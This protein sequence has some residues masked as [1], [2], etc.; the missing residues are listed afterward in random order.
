MQSFPTIHRSGTDFSIRPST[1]CRNSEGGFVIPSRIG[2][3]RAGGVGL[4]LHHTDE[5][6]PQTYGKQAR[7]DLN[8]LCGEGEWG[9]S[10]DP[11]LHGI[12]SDIQSN[13]LDDATKK[14]SKYKGELHPSIHSCLVRLLKC[15]RKESGFVVEEDVPFNP[16]LQRETIGTLSYNAIELVQGVGRVPRLTS[17]SNTTQTIY[18][19]AGTYETQMGAVVSQ[20][21][22]CLTSVVKAHEDWQD[23]IMGQS[24]SERAEIVKKLLATTEGKE[25]EDDVIIDE[26]G[27]EEEE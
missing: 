4:S 10:I 27:E 20:K 18:V 16:I 7:A 11:P 5:L 15:R 23:I 26:S 6:V 14:W 12:L 13:K 3:P 22:R 25:D 21:L 1:P 24:S 19:F 17:Q 9:A 8:K 2:S